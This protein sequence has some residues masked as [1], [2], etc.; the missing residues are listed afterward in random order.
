M[1]GALYVSLIILLIFRIYEKQRIF[2]QSPRKKIQTVDYQNIIAPPVPGRSR[3]KFLYVRT[4]A[5]LFLCL[6]K[7]DYLLADILIQV[8]IKFFNS[9]L[10][11]A[12]LANPKTVNDG[13]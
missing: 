6:A 8:F 7:I 10:T 3:S 2:L 12:A 11:L 5:I 1:V 9:C 4:L 13:K